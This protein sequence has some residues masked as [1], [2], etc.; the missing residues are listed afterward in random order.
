LHTVEVEDIKDEGSRFDNIVIGEILSIKKHPNADRLQ[1]TEVNIGKDENLNIVCGASN[2]EKGQR[3][4]TALIGAI[5][6][7]ELEIKE[8]EVR[9]ETSCGMLCAEDE[10]GLGD[11]HSGIMILDKHAKL[12][13]NLSE[14]LKLKDVIIEVDNKSLTNRPD[15]LNHMG[16]AK[17]ISAFL[18]VKLTKKFHKLTKNEEIKIPKE[19]KDLKVNIKDSTACPRYMALKFD[20]IKVEESPKWLQQRLIAVGIKPINNIVD[21]TNYVM[22]EVGQPMHAFDADLIDKIVVRKAKQGEN[23][24]TLEGDDK[25]LTEEM[26]VIAD[27]EKPIAIAGVIGGDNSGVKKDT[28]SVIFESANFESIGI[29]KTSKKLGLRTE[30]SIRYEKGLDPFLTKTA[31]NLVCKLMKEICPKAKINSELIDISSEKEEANFG[32][33]LGPIVVEID[34]IQ[35]RIGEKI[36][37][38]KIIQILEKL[39]FKVENNNGTLTIKIPTWRAT[40]DVSI[41]EDIVEEVARIYGY[42]N[43][44]EQKPKIKLKS[45]RINKKRNLERKIKN[46]LATGLSMNESQNYSFT[47]EAKIKKMNIDSSGYLKLANPLSENIAILRQSLIVN[48]L[49]NIKT[50]QAKYNEL[51]F[52]EI[53]DIYMGFNGNIKKDNLGDETL[54]YQE[55]RLGI[56][57]GTNKDDNNFGKLKGEIEYLL[58]HFNLSVNFNILEMAP[59][60]SNENICASINV[61]KIEI[62]VIS[63]VNQKV[64]RNLGIKKEV[65]VAEIIFDKLFNIISSKKNILHQQQNKFPTINRDLAFVIPKKIPYNNFRNEILNFNKLIVNVEL[66]DSYTGDKIEKSKKSL[67]FHINYQSQEKTLTADEINIVQE[68]LINNLNEKYDAVIRDF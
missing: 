56:V 32:L 19:I 20:N 26:L 16:I 9:G 5:L 67:A 36:D 39:F 64:L 18:D 62:G 44:I 10:L 48:L 17:E 21:I 12:G 57:Y 13:Q 42:E 47:S 46:I 38:K 15:L 8:A 52:F 27:S 24:T 43:I 31:L 54:P 7:N 2:I 61:D 60:W 37:P 28:E 6:P 58:K 23:I 29:R 50:N 14:Y 53:G 45:P 68:K 55:T 22:L 25:E 65:A 4:P 33:N 49:D 66:F 40:N 34:W 63:M 51:K 30:A 35:K 59:S 3:V 41:P 11:D 1:I